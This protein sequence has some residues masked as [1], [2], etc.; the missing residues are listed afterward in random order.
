MIRDQK[1]RLIKHKM[2]DRL[3]QTL[4]AA[5]RR[6]PPRARFMNCPK[7]ARRRARRCCR[8][9][10]CLDACGGGMPAQAG[11]SYGQQWQ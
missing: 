1:I 9:G 2:L 7:T 5:M 3:A 11:R 8:D 4:A 10:A 6:Y